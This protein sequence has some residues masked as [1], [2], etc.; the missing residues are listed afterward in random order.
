MKKPII[1]S[2]LGIISCM[3]VVAQDGNP[4]LNQEVI[5]VGERE[6]QVKEV[7]KQAFFPTEE[8][9]V[10]RKKD[11]EYQID[12]VIYK[13]RYVPDTIIPA[14]LRIL[15]PLGSL[16]RFYARAGA[17]LYTTTF[18]DV[19]Y[20][21]L[22]NRKTGLAIAYNHRA[23]QGGIDS[24]PNNGAFSNN[25]INLAGR[26]I[27]RKAKADGSVEFESI[28]R[29]LIQP[30]FT[31]ANIADNIRDSKTSYEIIRATANV[32]KAENRKNS[33]ALGLNSNINY[34]NFYDDTEIGFRL[35]GSAS[36]TMGNEK[37]KAELTT[38]YNN[39]GDNPINS[40]T[41][42]KLSPSV[43][44]STKKFYVKAGLSLQTNISNDNSNFS[45][46]P[47]IAVRAILWENY[48]TPYASFTGDYL[49]NN[50]SS[51]LPQN[52]YLYNELTLLNTREKINLNLGAR[53]RLGKKASFDL[54]Y[55]YRTY[56]DYLFYTQALFST[57]EDNGVYTFTYDGLKQS[58]VALEFAVIISNKMN[59]LVKSEYHSYSTD[60]I[61]EA[62]YLPNF[63][64]EWVLEYS[65]RKKFLINMGLSIIGSRQSGEQ[66]VSSGGSSEPFILVRAP[67]STELKPYADLSL[68]FEYRYNRR[69]SAFI[70]FNNVLNAKYQVYKPY[71]AQLFGVLGGLSYTF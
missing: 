53:V 51:I 30:Q 69:L 37:F 52:P 54:N 58:T 41:I 20:N 15:E 39:F 57:G 24:L 21:S 7:F 71:P 65:I 6:L 38:D 9:T 60:S 27:G 40:S 22:R 48:F 62:F 36:K 46:F 47:N 2:L 70:D 45:F 67:I 31:D 59:L 63:N 28:I 1:F 4:N 55:R 18:A 11:S 34:T 56:D 68:G 33:L 25:K 26:L 43:E 35:K 29:N 32:E 19:Y 23:S 5:A 42:V 16:N 17:G 61:S 50:L 44:T 10:V 12:P 14:N 64:S 3:V 13:T 8:D 49:R 66:F